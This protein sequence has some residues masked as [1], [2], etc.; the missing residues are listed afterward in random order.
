MAKLNGTTSLPAEAQTFLDYYKALLKEK[1]EAEATDAII[2]AI[3]K[4]YYGEMG[5]GGEP[6]DIRTNPVGTGEIKGNV[7]AFK[8]PPHKRPKTAGSS[9]A[10]PRLPVAL[11]FACLVVVYTGFRYFFR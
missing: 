4:S 6:P 1:T 11:I 10:R 2:N 5:G 3:Y 8:R 7:T 9:Q